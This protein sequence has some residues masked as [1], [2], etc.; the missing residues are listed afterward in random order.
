MATSVI[1][2]NLINS[3]RYFLVFT[4]DEFSIVEKNWNKQDVLLVGLSTHPVFENKT[5]WSELRPLHYNFL[6]MKNLDQAW[7]IPESEWFNENNKTISSLHFLLKCLIKC[8]EIRSDAKIDVVRIQSYGE[9]TV[10]INYNATIT[11][12]SI[13]MPKVDPDPRARFTVVVDN[14]NA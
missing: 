6:I 2:D 14:T 9:N 7:N 3:K 13:K 1:I 4:D 11:I 8:L 5:R 12:E 10:T